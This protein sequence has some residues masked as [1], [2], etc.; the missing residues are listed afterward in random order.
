MFGGIRHRLLGQFNNL[1]LGGVM[2][3]AETEGGL[4]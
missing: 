1:S 3:E 2:F 4:F